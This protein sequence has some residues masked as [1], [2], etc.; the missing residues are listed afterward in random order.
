MLRLPDA[1]WLSADARWLLAGRGVRGFGY[2]FMGVLLAVYLSAAGLDTAAIGFLFGISLGGSTVV[3]LLSGPLSVRFGRR[4]MLIGNALVMAAAALVFAATNQPWLLAIAAVTGTVNVSGAERGAF[5]TVE[6]AALPQTA[7][8]NR[9]TD[10]FAAVS[11]VGSI[12]AAAGALAAGF[13]ALLEHQ[14]GLSTVDAVRLMLVGYA[15]LALLSVVTSLKLSPAIEVEPVIGRA[16]NRLGISSSGG[17]IARLSAL[18]F[19]DS[20]GSGFILQS[21][22]A[23]W[24]Y[25][26]H[27]LTFEKLGGLFAASALF[28]AGS[29]WAAVWLSKR[30]GLVNT[31]VFTHI[32]ANLLL[33][34]LPF[35]PSVE[36]AVLAHLLRTALSQMDVPTRQ[37][38][39]MAV[40]QPEERVSAAALERMARGAGSTVSPMIAGV[41]L[42]AVAASVPFVLGGSIKA[43]Y[44]VAM[45]FAF[46]NLKPPEEAARKAA[47]S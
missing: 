30:I 4:A 46:R 32:P 15:A 36:L 42:Q 14:F 11:A 9:R 5:I 19:V 23:Y 47:G 20:F 35:M 45:W 28:E 29:F 44:D 27:G 33:I 21:F 31:M 16:T 6:Q 17:R 25:T 39:M 13:P 18:G 38:Y 10:V 40:V 26:T 8:D 34:A 43:A 1:T 7:P 24:F 3:T 41:V 2:G 12:A 22:I 37:S